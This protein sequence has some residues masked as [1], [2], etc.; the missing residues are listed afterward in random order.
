MGNARALFCPMV[1]GV[2]LGPLT[3]L[4]GVAEE[5]SLRGGHCA[6][7]VNE[8]HASVVRWLGYDYFVAPKPMRKDYDAPDFRLCDA[9]RALGIMDSEYLHEAIEAELS[10]IDKFKP[11]V[12]MS[13][14]KL[15]TPVTARIR[16]VPLVSIAATP[17]SPDFTSPMY[18]PEGLPEACSDEAAK[19]LARNGV[20]L[21]SGDIGELSYMMSDHA[22]SVVFP[23]FDPFLRHH[24]LL[25][26]GPLSCKG[27]DLYTPMTSLEGDRQL[28]VVYVNRGSADVREYLRALADAAADMPEYCFVV[29]EKAQPDGFEAPPNVTV[30]P[31][32]PIGRLLADARVLISGGGKNA[33]MQA[34]LAGVPVLGI[35]GPS[36][37]RDFNLRRVEALG[38]GLIVDP[39][40][41]SRSICDALR[42]LI[43]DTTYQQAAREASEALRQLPGPAGVANLLLGI[44]G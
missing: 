21:R 44:G 28:I 7:L 29:V 31:E 33:I 1:E 12:L 36:A 10:V 26:A 5:L 22:V 2:G 37:E 11:T 20:R 32:A 16:G 18:T 19:I 40:V 13:A 15:T 35:R 42:I 43:K 38:A 3:Q 39:P 25:Y 8:N 34:L 27:I 17:D 23:A 6:F 41:A 9:A 24:D 14:I 30:I 4:L